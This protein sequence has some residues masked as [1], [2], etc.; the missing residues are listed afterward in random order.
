MTHLSSPSH[1]NA[2]REHANPAARASQG[3]AGAV[4]AQAPS[5]N[6]WVVFAIVA[7]GVF[8]STL[9][10]SIV[11]ISLPTIAS[12]FQVPLNGAVEWI[13]IG[14]L[15]VIAATL[16]TIGRLADMT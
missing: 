8:M 3:Q 1:T 5:T 15:V 13:V 16:L 10:S 11:N 9:D 12:Y 14:Y 7:I 2:R 6:K 4:D